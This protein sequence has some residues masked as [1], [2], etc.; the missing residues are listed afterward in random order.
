MQTRPFFLIT[1]DD[2]VHAPGIILLKRIVEPF[3]DCA[4]VATKEQQSA[5]GSGLT[6]PGSSWGAEIVDG[7]EAIWIDGTPSDA[8]YF[9]FDYLKQKPDFVLSGVNLGVNIGDAMHRSGTVSAVVTAAQSR[10]TPGIAFSLVSAATSWYQDHGK[11]TVFNEQLLSYPGKLIRTIIEKALTYDFPANSFWNVNFPAE[12]TSEL[13]V[14][15]TGPGNHWNNNQTIAEDR[16]TY[17]YDHQTPETLI[18]CDIKLIHQGKATITPCRVSF[19]LESELV[20]LKQ[21]FANL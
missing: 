8:V 5:K 19:T 9:A 11:D 20:P 7:C 6:F 3:A 16:F 14:V 10:N 12:P 15:P 4:I 13:H 2:S 17:I 1:G 18:N 21:V